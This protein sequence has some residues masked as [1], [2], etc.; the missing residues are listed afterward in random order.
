MPDYDHYLVID[1]EASCDDR[2]SIPHQ[3]REIIEIGAVMVKVQDFTPV[4][5]WQSFVRPIRHPM[6]TPLCTRL[7]SIQQSDVDS[8]P[9]FPEAVAGLRTCR[10]R[11]PLDLTHPA[12]SYLWRGAP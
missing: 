11:R 2:G 8:A 7:T 12:P 4:D 3:D 1:L 9:R 6:L 5:E 10:V